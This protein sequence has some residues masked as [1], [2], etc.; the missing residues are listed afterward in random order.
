M[1]VGSNNSYPAGAL[2]NFT[3]RRFMFDG[4]VCAS[5]EGLLQAFKF[6]NM[7]AQTN[8]CALIGFNAK[9]KGKNRNKRWKSMQT[10][11]WQGKAYKRDSKEYQQLLDRAYSDLYFQDS[12]FRKAL[13]DAGNAI[14]THSIGHS[15]E[16]ETV[17]TE[18]EFCSRLQYLKD[19]GALYFNGEYRVGI[20][21]GK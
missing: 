14:F 18:R 21:I 11:W 3:A 12:S 19:F 17:L 20:K 9:F 10:L 15:N 13:E 16:K 6:E 7:N 2:S 1:D 4:V 5:M 8:T